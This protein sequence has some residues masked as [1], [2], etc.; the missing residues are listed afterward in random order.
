MKAKNL[1][2]RLCPSQVTWT[3]STGDVA[4][5]YDGKPQ[6]P[7]WRSS[8]GIVEVRDA[9]KGGV[10]RSIAA[11]SSRPSSGS[12]VLGNK[13]ETYGGGF[14]PQ[15][16]MHGDVANVRIWNRVIQEQEVLSNMWM[17]VPGPGRG[18]T[19]G[20]VFSYSFDPVNV[21]SDP[22]SS[23]GLIKDTYST[24]QNDLYLS[25]DAPQWLY[26]T[27]P[28]A[29]PDGTP[30]GNPTPGAAGH[31]FY[32]SDQQVLIHKNFHDFPSDELT[33]E[34]WMQSTDTCRKGVP[35]SYAT[36]GYAKADNSFLIFDYNDWGISVME[37][38]GHLSDHTSG[39]ASTDGLWT[40][41]A[42]RR[43]H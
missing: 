9:A 13:Q 20:L 41:V 6:T 2:P 19:S 26:S 1:P 12:L 36:G 40:H 43:E 37:D 35:F 39:V 42:V 15:Y 34:F 22:G 31:A 17:N 5:Y 23:R 24:F 16:S 4:L 27:A 14:S 3:K 21:H 18:E 25:A 38:E 33:V 8:A 32:L 7:F 30:V 28:L 29:L 11:G 10:T